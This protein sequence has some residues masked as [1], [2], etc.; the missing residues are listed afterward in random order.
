MYL[1]TLAK[2]IYADANTL[3]M[4]KGT[5]ANA[6]LGVFSNWGSDGQNYTLE[7]NGLYTGYEAG[8]QLTEVVACETVTVGENGNIALPMSAGAP[9]VLYAS[10]KLSGLCES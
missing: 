1:E 8:T 6:V 4:R 9:R 7:I 2:P 10:E 3:V 5:D